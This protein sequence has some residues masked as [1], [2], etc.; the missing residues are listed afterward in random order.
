MANFKTHYQVATIAS[1][2]LSATFLAMNVLNPAQAIHAFLIGSFSGLIPDVDSPHSISI[3]VAF[4]LFSLFLAIFL[5][6]SKAQTYSLVEI[7]VGVVAI[8]FFMQNIVIKIFKMQTRH[9]G[10]FHSVPAA[11]LYGLLIVLICHYFLKS[12]SF[13][14]WLFGFFAS[15][16]YLIHLTLDEI[17]SVDLSNQRLKSSFGTALKLFSFNTK[18]AQM[19][20]VI[21]YM[22]LFIDFHFAPSYASFVNALFSLKTWRQFLAVLI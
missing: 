9:R 2:S 13:D 22:L 6:F 18:M 5:V 20:S 15:F 3:Q 4:S 1:A 16:G 12:R 8:Y 19:Q 10:L 21:L 7:A 11:L 14:A 17:Y